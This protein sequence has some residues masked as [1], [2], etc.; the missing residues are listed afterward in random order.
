MSGDLG[1]GGPPPGRH[2]RAFFGLVLATGL[3][4]LLV[5]TLVAPLVLGTGYVARTMADRFLNDTC[6][7][8]EQPPPQRSVLLA[9]DA[10]TVIANFFTQNRAP[11]KLSA[12]PRALVHALVATEDRRFYQHHG[13]DLRGLLRAAVHDASGGDTQGGSTLTMQ[14][15]KQV[16]Y[17]QARTDA[18]RQAAIAP[19]LNRKLQN[20]KCA[21]ELERHATKDQ[22]LEKY[23]NIA[24]FGENSY[25]VA[26]AAKTYFGTSLP[27]LSVPQSALL[28]GL[29][30]APSQYDPFLHPD[31][32][33]HRRNEVLINMAEVGYLDPAS[34]ARYENSPLQLASS[35]RCPRGATT[36]TP[37]SPTRASSATSPCTGCSTTA[38]AT[39]N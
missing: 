13:V 36:P 33:L 10:K 38:S 8:H 15:V 2:I 16:R 28:V 1:W 31:L 23:L 20:A 25:G 21:L 39:R 27:R 12:V 17:Y 3:T 34:A 37:R 35:R 32:A 19:N 4:G 9:N 29:L 7:V 5:A 14:Y 24:F 26:V 30:Q 22:I 6:D 11:V 18:E